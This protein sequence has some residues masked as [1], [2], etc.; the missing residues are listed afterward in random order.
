MSCFIDFAFTE[1]DS[2][3][4]AQVSAYKQTIEFIE[5]N[6]SSLGIDPS[7][8]P[9]SLDEV[10][11][12]LIKSLTESDPSTATTRLSFT[13]PPHRLPSRLTLTLFPE[14]C[15]KTVENFLSK[16]PLHY[17]GNKVHRI[18]EGYI[19][20]WGDVVKGDGSSGDSI[21]GGKFN[22]EPQGL[23]LPISRG[24]LV[25]ANSGKHSNT[26]QV[27]VV[28]SQDVERIKKNMQGKHV[29]FGHVLGLGEGDD[30]TSEIAQTNLQ[31]MDRLDAAKESTEIIVQDC[32]VI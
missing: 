31:V 22:D 13:K 29:V 18:V 26:S 9:E 19:V 5:S 4:E 15:P 3:Y 16:K 21:Y 2:L 20:Q 1:A 6:A 14:K 23:K 17:K 27:F 10:S 11:I 28:L 24:S 32:G 8:A 25:M 30:V 7:T 12:E